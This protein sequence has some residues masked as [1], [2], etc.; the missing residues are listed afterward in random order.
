MNKELIEEIHEHAMMNIEI[1]EEIEK[2]KKLSKE[3]ISE[4]GIIKEKAKKSEEIVYDM[5][6]DLKSLD[7]AK[8]NLTFS[9]DALKKFIMMVDAIEKLREAC[10]HKHYGMIANLISAFNEL[11]K[12]F[13]KYE[14]IP[15]IQSLYKEKN[16]IVE[17]LFKV[18]LEDFEAYE[19]QTA[20][21]TP[22][23]IADAAKVIEVLG[24]NYWRKFGQAINGIILKQYEEQYGSPE[25][26]VLENTER[27]FGFIKRKMENFKDKFGKVMPV[28]WGMDCLLLYEFCSITRIH[29]NNILERTSASTSVAILMKALELSLKFE[30][31]I[32]DLMTK[33]YE[34]LIAREKKN[35]YDLQALPRFA[36]A[37][38]NSFERYLTPYIKSEEETLAE[39]LFKH[40][41]DDKIS[42][43]KVYNSALILF[44]GVKNSVRRAS[45]FSKGSLLLEIL[46]VVKKMFVIYSERCFEKSK[47]CGEA[48]EETICWIVNTGEYCKNII[49]GVREVFEGAIEPAFADSIEFS[50]EE[51]VFSKYPPP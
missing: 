6:K 37:I 41:E 23:Q 36:G 48:F 45:N 24:E 50:N 27:R 33:K 46:K 43:L 10:E 16:L 5:C 15:Q 8:K 17:E 28:E 34:K 11:S 21:V 47:R 42:E 49:E 20:P 22:E 13:K 29:I 31:K 40:L 1:S 14:Q 39:T 32:T 3:I 25:S 30:N 9:I 2:A 7:I 35:K 19:N 12:Y 4:I 38:S 51:L 26:A 18:V 44:H